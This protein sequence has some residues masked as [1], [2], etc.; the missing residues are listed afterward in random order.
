MFISNSLIKPDHFVVKFIYRYGMP[1][2][3]YSIPAASIN[4]NNWAGFMENEKE[5]KKP[6]GN[7]FY[8]YRG[9]KAGARAEPASESQPEGEA[10][11]AEGRDAAE[12][13]PEASSENPKES[14]PQD[15]SARR[16][17]IIGIV[18][19][20]LFAAGVLFSIIIDWDSLWLTGGAATTKPKPAASSTL[21][22]SKAGNTDAAL[23]LYAQPWDDKKHDALKSL[24]KVKNLR[25]ALAFLQ[26][27]TPKEITAVP[28]LPC[29]IGDVAVNY[30]R[31]AGSIV[32]FTVK[33]SKKSTVTED[34]KLESSQPSTLLEFPQDASYGSASLLVLGSTLDGINAGDSI[35]CRCIP[36]YCYSPKDN[37]SGGGLLFITI[38]ELAYKT[39]Q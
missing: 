25:Y 3:K 6:E 19:A 22:P 17:K 21:L 8:T 13:E 24:G 18:L 31:L 1:I 27:Y 11:K 30:G 39:K 23:Y 12:R 16:G 10:P 5:N 34:L 7:S 37:P 28:S 20:A 2:A 26:N 15:K 4:R 29:N 9:E 35:T 33:I 14:K 36:I 32:T 38:P